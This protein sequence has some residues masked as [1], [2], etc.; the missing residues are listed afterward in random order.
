MC[1]QKRACKVCGITIFFKQVL[2]CHFS[3]V[4]EGNV[5][6]GK[7]NILGCMLGKKIINE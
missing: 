4:V 3:K 2:K 5:E 6:S 1:V 7:F